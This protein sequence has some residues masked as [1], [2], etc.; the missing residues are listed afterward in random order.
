MKKIILVGHGASGK[1]FLRKKFQER[2]FKFAITHTTRPPRVGEVDGVDCNFVSE[3][4]FKRLIE[5]DQFLEYVQF[6]GWYYGT[7][8]DTFNECDVFIMTPSGVSK[9]SKE[10]RDRCFII[11]ID[12]AEEI[13]LS[14]L[15]SRVMPGDTAL[16]RLAADRLDFCDFRDFDMRVT[17]P[18]F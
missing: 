15:D 8:L 16:R 10:N 1:D 3:E 6:N 5:L 18:D 11:F 14:R 17:N 4:E 12:I 7:T 13:R 2:N 9:L